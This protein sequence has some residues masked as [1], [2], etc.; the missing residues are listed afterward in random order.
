MNAVLTTAGAIFKLAVRRKLATG[1][2]AADAER[3]SMGATELKDEATNELRGDGVQPL[4]PEEVLDPYEI[5]KVLEKVEPGYYRTL[6]L[7]A[8]LTGMKGGELFALRWSDIELKGI[9]AETGRESSCG[10]F[11][12]CRALSWARVKKDDGPIRP[13]FFPPKTKADA[14]TLPIPM[15]LG[16]AFRLVAGAQPRR[17]APSQHALAASLLCVG[18]DHGGSTGRRGSEPAWTLQSRG[19]AEGLF[20]LVHER[21]DR[22]RGPGGE[23]S[24][25]GFQESWTLFGHF[26]GCPQS[27]YRINT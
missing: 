18:A 11:F 5:R 6:F 7:T 26:R 4:R 24:D 25:G 22:F 8:Y 13:R 21:R 23:E 12:V 27:E 9:D 15:E 16:A 1:N 10:R 2:P 3:A 20:A 17:F 14:R 19:L